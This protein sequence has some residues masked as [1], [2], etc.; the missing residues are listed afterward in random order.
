MY[1][2]QLCVHKKLSTKN[3]PQCQLVCALDNSRARD[4]ARDEGIE[5]SNLTPKEDKAE[6]RREKRI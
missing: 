3:K 2:E 4:M 6:S 5:E 1:R